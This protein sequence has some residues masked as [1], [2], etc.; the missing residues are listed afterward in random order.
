LATAIRASWSGDDERISLL[1]GR[2]GDVAGC[3]VALDVDAELGKSR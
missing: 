1:G 2:R 3:E